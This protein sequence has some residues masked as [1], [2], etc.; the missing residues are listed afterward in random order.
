MEPTLWWRDDDAGAWTLAL[1]RLV[2]LA[3]RHGVPLAVAAV[4]M[5]V[6][7]EAKAQLL[8]A[9]GVTLLLHGHSHTNHAPASAKKAEFG[10]HRP[11]PAMIAEIAEA[12]RRLPEAAPVF[13][14]P[15]NRIDPGLAAALPSLGLHG[16]STHGRKTVDVP[17][18]RQI[19]TTV[20]PIDWHNGRR[21]QGAAATRAALVAAQPHGPVGL[22]T[23]HAVMDEDMWRFLDDFLR[24]SSRLG[25]AHWSSADQLFTIPA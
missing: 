3:V 9:P 19:N 12:R 18:V 14:P 16:L 8:A 15:W 10:P 23:H 24:E 7:D 13:V 1:A 2:A 21:F 5:Q 17:G 20:D 4:P 11:L 6:T 25:G 22:L